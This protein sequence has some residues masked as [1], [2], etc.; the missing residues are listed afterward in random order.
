M[1]DRQALYSKKRFLSL[2]LGS[3]PQPSDHRWDAL[4]I[5]LP[6]LRR[7]ATAGTFPWSLTRCNTCSFNGSTCISGP[8]SNFV[9]RHCFTCVSSNLIYCISCNRYC[10]LNIGETG[11]HLS[12]RFV[13]HLRSVSNGDVDK[14]VTRHFNT[15]DHSYSDMKV[16]TISQ[17]FR[18]NNNRKR[19]EMRLI[20]KIGTIYLH[21]LNE[22]FCFT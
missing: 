15:A 14:P 16:C 11:R 3:N 5:E 9:V 18:G 17:I 12:D 7:L 13:E 21:G 6:R 22:R 8:K 19:Q 10:L 2:R 1:N 20:F 4:T